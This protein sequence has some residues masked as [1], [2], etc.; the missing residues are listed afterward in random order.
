MSLSVVGSVSFGFAFGVSLFIEI[1]FDLQSSG[2]PLYNSIHSLKNSL[3]PGR[4]LITVGAE[5]STDLCTQ[6]RSG[7]RLV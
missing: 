1:A 2:M 5:I 6:Y 4:S 7:Q 3:L